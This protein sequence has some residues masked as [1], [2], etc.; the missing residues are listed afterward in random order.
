MEKIDQLKRDLNYNMYWS[1]L[2]DVSLNL[3]IW[4]F[5]FRYW[6]ISFVMLV[7]LAGK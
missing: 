3:T 2:R 6:N 1:C 4:C 7:Q 5:S